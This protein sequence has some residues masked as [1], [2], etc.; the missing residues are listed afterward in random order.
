MK[1]VFLS[2][3]RIVEGYGI[4]SVSIFFIIALITNH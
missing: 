4:W 2:I 3:F 1:K